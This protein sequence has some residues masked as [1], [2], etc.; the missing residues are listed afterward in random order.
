MSVD[1]KLNL[2]KPSKDLRLACMGYEIISCSFAN[3]ARLGIK[4]ILELLRYS[5]KDLKI[6]ID[7]S[8]NYRNLIDKIILKKKLS[9][10]ELNLLKTL[11]KMFTININKDNEKIINNYLLEYI[12]NTHPKVLEI[13]YEIFTDTKAKVNIFSLSNT[14]YFDHFLI[15]YF[16]L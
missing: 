6:A 8:R 7:N 5:N 15:K 4:T 16:L 11:N 3:A 1:I 10:E 14:H 13:I 9:K 12:E 2:I